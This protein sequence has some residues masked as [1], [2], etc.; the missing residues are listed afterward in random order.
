MYEAFAEATK[1]ITWAISSGVGR[2]DIYDA[3]TPPLQHHPQFV[4]HA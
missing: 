3:S 1:A 2:R 4:L